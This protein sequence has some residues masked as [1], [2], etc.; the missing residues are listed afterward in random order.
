MKK[1]VALS[2]SL[3]L[4]YSICFSQQTPSS[5][6]TGLAPENYAFLNANSTKYSFSKS[7]NRVLPRKLPISLDMYIPK[8]LDQGSQGSCTAFAVAAALSIR[9]NYLE[10]KTRQATNGMQILY[11]PT[12]IWVLGK[13]EVIHTAS[14]SLDGIAYSKAFETLFRNNLVLWNDFPYDPT[15]KN[16]CHSSLPPN[17]SKK[18]IDRRFSYNEVLNNHESIKRLLNDGFPIC[19]SVFLDLGFYNALYD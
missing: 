17:I 15:N 11:S 8:V 4:I 6:S 10:K 9:Q 16:L 19:I 13:R 12:F 3:I 18:I 2:L 14:C 1:P 5:I 7:N